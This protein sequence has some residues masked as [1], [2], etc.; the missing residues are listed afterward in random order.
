M[1]SKAP[2][3]QAPDPRLIDANVRALERQGLQADRLLG[4]AEYNLPIQRQQM[5]QAI[6]A[7]KTAEDRAAEQYALARP[8]Q[9]RL[10]GLQLGMVQEAQQFN[11]PQRAAEL[12]GLAQADI[13]QATAQAFE[14]AGRS[15]GRMGLGADR[16]AGSIADRALQLAQMQV[17]AA[18]GTRQQALTEQRGLMDRA[19]NALA[20][21]P[22]Q[23]T[24]ATSAGAGY[25]TMGL[26]LANTGM[27]GQQAGFGAAGSMYGQQA[28]G[29]N[30]AYGTQA[31]AYLQGQAQEGQF[32]GSLLGAGATLGAAGLG[33]WGQVSAAKAS[34]RRLKKDI[35]RVGRDPRSGLNLY[36][37]A[38]INDNSGRR[39]RGVMADEVEKFDKDAVTYDDL[40]FASVNY[41]RLGLEM[42]EV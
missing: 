41:A 10:R 28:A 17:G 20:G 12:R 35:V 38:Y 39:Y 24:G 36:E 19:T 30:Q 11:V 15:A 27:G 26:G 14:Q 32:W 5:E 40:G 31:N 3:I 7:S 18:A 8:M 21:Y 4:I 37:F 23:V 33:A 13:A 25:G 1:G 9:E 6:A 22:A 16:M 42:V 2:D 34:D 29:L